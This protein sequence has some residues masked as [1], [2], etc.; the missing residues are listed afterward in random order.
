MFTTCGGPILIRLDRYYGTRSGAAG[1]ASLYTPRQPAQPPQLQ[2][3]GGT[4]TVL[5]VWGGN[6]LESFLAM[7]KPFEDATGVKV[8]FE[9]TRDLNAVLT[10]R[11]QGGNP[12]EEAGMTVPAR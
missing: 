10:T 6:E 2:Q 11:L 8:Q 5:G 1:G 7:V 9:G 3:L 12:P 4:V